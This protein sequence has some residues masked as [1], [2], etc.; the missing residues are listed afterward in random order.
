MKHIKLLTLLMAFVFFVVACAS[1]TLTQE[2]NDDIIIGEGIIAAS[3][4]E[5]EYPDQYNTYLRNSEMVKTTYGGSEPYDYLEKY[6][7]LLVLYDGMGFSKDYL[8]ARGHVYSLEDVIETSRPKPGASCLSCKTPDYLA[9]VNEYGT[10]FY[11]MDF[12]EMAAKVTSPI[13]C[14]D[15]HTNTPGEVVLTRDH[16]QTA[17]DKMEM[18]FSMNN[19]VCAQCH[20]E[21]YLDPETKEVTLPWDNGISV[22][23][24]E[25]YFDDKGYYDWIHP[26]TGTPLL[27]VQHP[28]FETYMMGSVHSN[29]GMSCVDCHMP[30]TEN[31]DGDIF[32]S[33]HWTSPLHTIQQSCMSCHTGD[34]QD[35]IERVENIQKG[36]ADKTNEVS[37]LIVELIEELTIA[38]ESGTYSEEFLDQVRDYHRKAQWRWDFVFVENSTGF[39]N[40]QLAHETLDAARQYAEEGLALLRGN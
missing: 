18:E 39:H 30:R 5:E 40:S 19:L 37:A 11:A 10:E 27:K 16:L 17:L 24:I 31:D 23:G 21:Y 26:T 4:W 29:L 13:S 2:E 33:H 22:D 8:R 3:E 20:V 15:C 34:P 36:V 35:L 1:P 12:D 25:K 28:E 38:I 14:Y 32:N 7:D 9:L 6:P